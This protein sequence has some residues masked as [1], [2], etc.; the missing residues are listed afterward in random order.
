VSILKPLYGTEPQL[1]RNLESFFTQDYPEFEI[2]FGTRSWEDPAL[3]V[4]ERLCEKYP[5]VRTRIV[6]SG[7]PY[8][9]NAKVFSLHRMFAGVTGSYFVISDS[10]VLVRRDFLRNVV[11]PLL[12]SRVGLVTCLYEGIP[13]RDFWSTLEALG[14]TVEMSS[15]VLVAEM[16]DGM[17]FAMGAVMAVR[18]DALE[19]IGGIRSLADFCADDFLLGKRIAKCG[20]QVV[21]SH[22][23]VGHVLADRSA[24]RS[25]SDQLRWMKSTRFSRPRG[26]AG[27][28]LTYAVPFGLLALLL[29]L[30]HPQLRYAGI[31]LFVAAC[32]NRMLLST[33]IGWGVMRDPRA[34]WSCWLYPLRDLL[35]F[36]IWVASFGGRTFRWRGETYQFEDEG[37][38]TPEQ[39]E[40]E[41]VGQTLPQGQD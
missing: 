28:G 40:Y 3:R 39:R 20:Y 8:W 12:D 21:L 15:G 31:A 26:H 5:Q 10:D 4:V 14:M 9:P 36:G 29:S 34:L 23:K 37:R 19:A 24:S 27:S 16:V 17:K 35:G 2:I 7:E 32:V 22:Y 6:V 25:F 30:G 1:E 33:L 13:A 11:P 18:R 38:I 41:L